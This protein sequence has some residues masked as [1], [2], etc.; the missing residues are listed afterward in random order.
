MR[1]L[2]NFLVNTA[3]GAI[4]LDRAHRIVFWN[5]AAEGLFGFKAEEV[6]GRFC[7]EVIA[8]RNES[9]MLLCQVNCLD[10]MQC[11]ERETVPSQ[12]I[13]VTTKTGREVWLS[14]STIVVPSEWRDVCALVHFFR[15]ISHQ[16]ELEH[17]V[18]QFLAAIA[19]LSS[20]GVTSPA[21]D[22]PPSSLLLQL[23]ARERE[24]LR[25]LASGSST[26]VIATKLFI[27]PA[28]VRN[29]VHNILRKL[30]VKNRFEA[31]IIALRS[32]LI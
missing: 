25:L 6:R 24:V 29:H 9:G 27:S 17:S 15:N 10:K 7:Y 20:S 18:Q 5:K 21:P 14:M 22:S 2:L 4:A 32:G 23:T 8:G 11:L 26:T 30:G 28:T 13:L 1:N 12:N 31:T 3:D 19:Q 16:K